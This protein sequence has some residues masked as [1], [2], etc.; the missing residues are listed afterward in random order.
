LSGGAAITG[1]TSMATSMAQVTTRFLFIFIPLESSLRQ[2]MSLIE[3]Q[4]VDA[5]NV[6]RL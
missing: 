4:E 3:L 2:T 6:A 5:Q 1:R